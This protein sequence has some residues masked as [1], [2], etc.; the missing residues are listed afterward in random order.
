MTK[1]FV[2]PEDWSRDQRLLHRDY[3][4]RAR[5]AYEEYWFRRMKKA[6]NPNSRYHDADIWAKVGYAS[7]MNGI[8]PEDFIAA[9]VTSM[10]C[11][12]F[13]NMLLGRKSLDNARRYTASFGTE[14]DIARIGKP[15]DASAIMRL[16]DQLLERRCTAV[17]ERV[18]QA[19]GSNDLSSAE[20]REQVAA[21][22]N[23]FDALG[24]LLA[25]PEPFYRHLYAEY[26]YDELKF[27]HEL[28]SALKASVKYNATLTCINEQF[29][30]KPL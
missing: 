25:C 19:F 3:T 29:S 28:L 14:E 30:S 7:M 22:P 5:K 16:S 15:V 8:A 24:M 1:K 18:K 26:A 6:Y 10:Q 9:Q 21:Q 11:L 12:T 2:P 13:P 27:E 20:I 23:R 4:K 17:L